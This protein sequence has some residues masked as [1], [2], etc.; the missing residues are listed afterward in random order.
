MVGAECDARAESRGDVASLADVVASLMAADL[1]GATG[2]RAETALTLRRYVAGVAV[3]FL[4]LIGAATDNS[5]KLEAYLFAIPTDASARADLDIG[6]LFSDLT[7]APTSRHAF[8]LVR[9]F[10]LIVAGGRDDH[11]DR[12]KEERARD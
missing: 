10:R 12:S 4:G 11:R 2:G 3:R 5:A 8:G 9:R 1:A 7:A 6:G